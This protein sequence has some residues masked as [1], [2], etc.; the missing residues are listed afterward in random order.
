MLILFCWALRSP[1]LDTK[2]QHLYICIYRVSSTKK[3]NPLRNVRLVNVSLKNCTPVASLITG[4]II[5]QRICKNRYCF[6]DV[7]VKRNQEL[8]QRLYF[9][10]LPMIPVIASMK[11]CTSGVL[12]FCL[13]EQ[14]PHLQHKC[15]ECGPGRDQDIYRGL[16]AI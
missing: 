7:L 14:L 4:T 2:P 1:G 9:T 16:D 10:D 3:N 12:V 8:K 15:Q 13:R 11:V 5:C 6:D